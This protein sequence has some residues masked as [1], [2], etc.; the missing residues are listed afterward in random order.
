MG[1]ELPDGTQFSVTLKR[2]FFFFKATEENIKKEESQST[3]VISGLK[4]CSK[5]I[6]SEHSMKNKN[7]RSRVLP[8]LPPGSF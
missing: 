4:F 1:P 6:H 8:D 7:T 3:R 5:R 2:F